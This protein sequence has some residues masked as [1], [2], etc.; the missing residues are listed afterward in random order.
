MAKRKSNQNLGSFEDL[1]S[2]GALLRPG[3][4]QAVKALSPED[5]AGLGASIIVA[6]KYLASDRLPLETRFA[7]VVLELENTF[8]YGAQWRFVS[9]KIQEI[10]RSSPQPGLKEQNS[11]TLILGMIFETITQVKNEQAA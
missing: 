2:I 3:I 8:Q 4:E 5:C 1:I 9:A 11:V 10:S 7:R 6:E